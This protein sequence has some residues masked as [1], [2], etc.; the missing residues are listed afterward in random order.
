MTKKRRNK[1][2]SREPNPCLKKERPLMEIFIFPSKKSN[3]SE[4]ILN[5][6]L[7]AVE[8]WRQLSIACSICTLIDGRLRLKP[9]GGWRP[10]CFAD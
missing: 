3:V 7:P 2:A 4:T 9:K 8:S 10:R 5:T 6:L 1:M